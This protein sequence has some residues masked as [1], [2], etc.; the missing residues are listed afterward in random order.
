[1]KFKNGSVYTYM[2]N[3]NTKDCW[4]LNTVTLY[5]GS[6]KIQYCI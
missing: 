1:M 5:N 2:R 4:T 6:Q 3:F